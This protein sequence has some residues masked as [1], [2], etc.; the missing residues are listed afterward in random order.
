[1]IKN[2]TVIWPCPNFTSTHA[3]GFNRVTLCNPVDDIK[4]V[5]VLF[6]DVVSTKPSEVIPVSQL[7]PEFRLIL[8][9]WTNPDSSTVPIGSS[10]DQVADRTPMNL[11][12]ALLVWDFM[13]TLQPYLNGKALLLCHLVSGENTTDAGGICCNRLFHENVFTGIHRSLEMLWAKARWCGKKD[14]IGVAIH[15]GLVCIKPLVTSTNAINLVRVHALD[16]SVGLL[17][18]ATEGV[19]HGDKFDSPVPGIDRLNRCR[20]SSPTTTNKPNLNGVAPN[21]MR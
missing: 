13:S 10:K 11:I 17:K 8:L 15:D 5:N 20:R 12:D 2:L 18:I 9:S 6:V 21:H 3:L 14:D 16:G 1:M 4:V 19:S 7:V